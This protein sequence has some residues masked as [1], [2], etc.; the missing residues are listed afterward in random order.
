MVK[1]LYRALCLKYLV[2]VTVLIKGL[3]VL[4]QELSGKVLC[5]P[6]CSQDDE[7]EAIVEL[8]RTTGDMFTEDDCEVNI[9]TVIKIFY[10]KF[11][12]I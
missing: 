5:H 7:L 9:C 6:I 4:L 8:I 11:K 10:L 2:F 12:L 1:F 3:V